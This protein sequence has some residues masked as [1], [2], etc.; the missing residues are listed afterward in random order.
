MADS[1]CI[2]KAAAAEFASAWGVGCEGK[3]GVHS[4]ARILA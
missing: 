2:L 3:R 4:D 1:A